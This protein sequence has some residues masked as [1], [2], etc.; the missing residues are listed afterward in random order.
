MQRDDVV[1]T[2]IAS[3]FFDA[4]DSCVSMTANSMNPNLPNAE[5]LEGE[6]AGVFSANKWADYS[7]GR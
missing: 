5:G 7:Q 3:G 4:L 6:N 1:G 2:F